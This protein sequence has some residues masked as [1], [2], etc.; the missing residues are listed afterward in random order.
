MILHDLEQAL[1]SATGEHIGPHRT[2]AFIGA[3]RGPYYR[4]R[5]GE[6]PLPKYMRRSIVAHIEALNR[7]W[8]PDVPAVPAEEQ[9]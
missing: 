4:W 6:K 9:R 1:S 8:K 2:C 5:R 3:T 7:G